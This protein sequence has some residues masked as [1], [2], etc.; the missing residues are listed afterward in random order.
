MVGLSASDLA[1]QLGVSKGRVSQYVAAGR[2]DGCFDGDGRAR[3]FYLDRVA[4]ALGR[5]LDRGQMLGNGSATK[6]ALK[7]ITDDSDDEDDSPAPAAPHPAGAERL[8]STDPSAYDMARTQIAIEDARKRRRDNAMAEGQFVLAEE[9]SRQ[10]SRAIGQE[11]REFESVLRDGA[12][13]IA[14]D[15]G[16]DFLKARQ[17]LVEVFRAHRA[18]RSAVLADATNDLSLTDAEKA[19]NI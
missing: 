7:K 11:I 14:D 3:R 9:V 18:T 12:R 16:V 8:K 1:K 19:A 4:V 6:A 15:L 5:R 10:V 13:K 17:L 2:L